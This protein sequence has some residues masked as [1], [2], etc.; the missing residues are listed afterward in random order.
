MQNLVLLMIPPQDEYQISLKTGNLCL[1]RF[2]IDEDASFELSGV[3]DLQKS[4]NSVMNKI[5]KTILGRKPEGKV[6]YRYLP[7]RYDKVILAKAL[8]VFDK[9]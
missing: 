7:S 8:H 6:N 5:R 3:Y 2:C 9:L 4:S 1:N